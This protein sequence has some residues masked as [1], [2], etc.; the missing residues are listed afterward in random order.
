MPRRT[1]LRAFFPLFWLSL[2]SMGC[3]SSETSSSSPPPSPS[4]SSSP[5][6]P[7]KP[8]WEEDNFRLE[9]IT[10]ASYDSKN[11]GRFSIRL[12]AKSPF[13]VNQDYPIAVRIDAPPEVKVSKK[14]LSREDAK[15][16]SEQVARF[17]VTFEAPSGK[18]ELEA[19]V[20]FAVCTPESCMPDRRKL[21]V[22][23]EVR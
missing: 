14:N 11:E 23:L 8:R 22:A 12:Q 3:G 4:A 6:S 21:L 16:F 15:E 1:L 13:H 9:A 10:E 2:G 5:S 18:H 20:D 7:S 19:L 17:D